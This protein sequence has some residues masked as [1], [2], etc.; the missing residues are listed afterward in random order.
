[1]FFVIPFLFDCAIKY[2]N[3]IQKFDAHKTKF[4]FRFHLQFWQ[5]WFLFFYFHTNQCLEFGPLV[6][7][8]T[9]FWVEVCRVC[10]G[11]A[12]ANVDLGLFILTLLIDR[13]INVLL[14]WTWIRKEFTGQWAAMTAW[15]VIRD[16]KRT[17]NILQFLFRFCTDL[18]LQQIC[19]QNMMC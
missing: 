5:G 7:K 9:N 18:F 17:R 10:C 2:S 12:N 11:Y 6:I 13:A 15:Y 3:L 19:A 14:F 4:W 8:A 16:G 1:M